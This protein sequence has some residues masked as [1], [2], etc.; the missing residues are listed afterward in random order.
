MDQFIR[1]LE[2]ADPS[3]C[4]DAAEQA[5]VADALLA[6]TR[7]FQQP[8]DIVF[9]HIVAGNLTLSTAKILIEAG[10]L[11]TWAEAGGGPKSSAELARLSG[12]DPDLI[13]ESAPP[14][15]QFR[16]LPLG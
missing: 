10:V 7:R 3:G 12:T 2:S 1:S 6:A 13:S 11:Q 14:P 15:P 5:R 9:E 8:S 16:L 4:S